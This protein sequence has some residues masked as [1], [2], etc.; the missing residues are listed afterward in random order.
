MICNTNWQWSDL[1]KSAASFAFS[2]KTGARGVFRAPVHA[3]V[4]PPPKTGTAIIE[5]VQNLV[6]PGT[7]QTAVPGAQTFVHNPASIPAA[8]QHASAGVKDVGQQ[9]SGFVHGLVE[10]QKPVLVKTVNKHGMPYRG[11]AVND[12]KGRLAA[13]NIGVHATTAQLNAFSTA[14]SIY[15]RAARGVLN[16]VVPG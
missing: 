11:A 14:D 1:E 6:R 9:V 3:P 8:V 15:G 4:P 16:Y 5:G 13:Q 12:A 2:A 10:P 7:I